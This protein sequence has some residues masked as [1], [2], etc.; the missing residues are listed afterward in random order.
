MRQVS[1][2]SFI[3]SL[4]GWAGSLGDCQFD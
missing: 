1:V 2:E 4:D 3:A